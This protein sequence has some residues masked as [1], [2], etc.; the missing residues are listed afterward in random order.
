M[1]DVDDA[2][3]G[4]GTERWRGDSVLSF[5]YHESENRNTEQWTLGGGLNHGGVLVAR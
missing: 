3:V 2:S 4:K 5:A 1:K